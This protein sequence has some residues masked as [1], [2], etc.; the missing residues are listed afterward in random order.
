[1]IHP[2]RFLNI[3]LWEGMRKM[4]KKRMTQREIVRHRERER[5]REVE[6]EMERGRAVTFTM[7][8]LDG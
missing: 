6:R 3:S 7:F 5:E 1:M 4:D 2:R 8:F